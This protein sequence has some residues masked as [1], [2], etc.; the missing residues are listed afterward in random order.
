M[1]IQLDNK[2]FYDTPEISEKTGIGVVTLRHYI[3]SGKL[4][5]V[6]VGVKY[7]VEESS[8]KEVFEKG[9]NEPVKEPHKRQGRR[10]SR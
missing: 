10:V 4:K 8:L 1:Q 6:K 7:W 9:I 3:R 5:G 2:T